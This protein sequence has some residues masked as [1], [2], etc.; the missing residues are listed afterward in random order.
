MK[1]LNEKY[2]ILLFAAVLLA[3]VL[4]AVSVAGVAAKVLRAFSP[5]FIGVLFALILNVVLNFFEN[6]AFTFKKAKNK[7]FKRPF[8]L[9]L[10]YL[11]FFGSAAGLF[12]LAFPHIADSVSSLA[13][14]IPQY[15]E[16]LS[17]RLEKIAAGRAAEMLAPLFDGVKNSAAGLSERLLGYVPKLLEFSKNIFN[18]VYDLIMGIALS[19]FVL[20]RKEKLVF[21]FKKVLRAFLGEQTAEKI[22]RI[23]LIANKKLSRFLAGQTFECFIVGTACFVGMIIFKIPYAVLVSLIIGVTNFIPMIG[24]VIGTIPSALIIIIESPIKALYFLIIENVVQQLESTFIYPKVVG[25][26][27]GISALWVFASVLVLGNL[28][29]F[30]GM[31][32]GV[33]LF[34]CLYAVVGG[35]VNDKLAEKR[36]AEFELPLYDDKKE[37]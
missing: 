37:F 27:L 9:F 30:M 18:G 35:I 25:E 31:F 17:E 13:E 34:A 22:F 28:F 15:A 1:K 10:T 19:I 36:L 3:V 16:T 20:S 21:Q 32:L 8:N 6:K 7:K 14:R 12:A 2:K 23:V 33:P 11:C 29:G 4:N 24:P 5:V 26:K